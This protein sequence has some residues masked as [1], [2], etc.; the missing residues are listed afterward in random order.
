[1]TTVIAMD[2]FTQAIGQRRFSFLRNMRVVNQKK[3]NNSLTCVIL[4]GCQAD[5]LLLKRN[6]W[7]V[8]PIMLT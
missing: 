2:D 4:F 6:L 7:K 3:S 1:M 8:M 5:V